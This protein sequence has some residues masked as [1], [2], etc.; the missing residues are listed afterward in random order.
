MNDFLAIILFLMFCGVMETL[1]PGF[2]FLILIST[3]IGYMIHI[4]IK[5]NESK[6]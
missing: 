2:G 1:R 6:S 4:I 5:K 3:I